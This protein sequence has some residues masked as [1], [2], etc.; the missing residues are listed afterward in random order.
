[1][2][3]IFTLILLAIAITGFSQNI[4]NNSFETWVTTGTGSN[5]YEE[6]TFWSTSDTNIVIV[7]I[8]NVTKSTTAQDGSFAAQL[9]STEISAAGFGQGTA[10]A[11][12][13]LGQFHLDVVAQTGTIT[14]G[15]PDATRYQTL[16]GYY[17]FAPVGGDSCFIGVGLFKHNA[18][19][20]IPDTIGFAIFKTGTAAS[21]WTAFSIDLEY[22]T[23][24]TP[25]TMNVIIM[26]SDGRDSVHAGTTLLI[27]NLSLEGVVS[28]I[29]NQP[30]NS[31]FQVY[32]NPANEELNIQLNSE[33][34]KA[35]ISIYNTLGE[36]VMTSKTNSINNK[37]S[38]RNLPSGIY[39]IDV[40]NGVSKHQQKIVKN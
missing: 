24:E 17:Q 31:N 18:I 23:G 10:P 19:T 15:V 28:G 16:K 2:K 12:L 37:L 40:N 32:P 8:N 38:I 3:K 29:A 27:D 11:V 25:D 6:P 13:T 39:I 36:L 26:S 21:T 5:S 14:G 33:N 7:T 22:R 34:N 35:T 4:P 30:A 1:M 9:Q 20:N